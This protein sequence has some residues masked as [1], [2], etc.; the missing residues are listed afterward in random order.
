MY[1]ICLGLFIYA[2]AYLIGVKKNRWLLSG[3]NRGRVRDKEKLTRMLAMYNLIS[4]VTLVLIGVINQP[5]FIYLIFLIVIGYVG[6]YFYANR[7]M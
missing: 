5:R 2:T 1:L 3:F 6:L 7:K 4:S